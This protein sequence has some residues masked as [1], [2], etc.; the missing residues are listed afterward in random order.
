MGEFK[1][2]R[3]IINIQLTRQ[4][5]MRY[6]GW[7]L[8]LCVLIISLYEFTAYLRFEEYWSELL[9]YNPEYQFAHAQ[10]RIHFLLNLASQMLMFFIGI[11]V[12]A[13]ISTHRTAGPLLA[14]RRTFREIRDGK[15]ETRLKFRKYDRLTEVEDDFNEMM[16]ALRRRLPPPS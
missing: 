13:V 4:Y 6:F 14:L 9:K 8:L 11:G 3:K 15:I 5:R 10:N 7:W 1:S 16:D 12:L 2:R